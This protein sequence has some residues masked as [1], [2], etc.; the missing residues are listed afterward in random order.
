VVEIANTDGD[1]EEAVEPGEEMGLEDDASG[2]PD[3]DE[4]M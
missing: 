1:E 4:D 2:L 3:E